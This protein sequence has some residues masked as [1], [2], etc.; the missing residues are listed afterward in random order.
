MRAN[1]LKQM[2]RRVLPTGLIR[3]LV[4]TSLKVRR[5]LIWPLTCPK[6][7][8]SSLRR[9][10]DQFQLFDYTEQVVRQ[11]NKFYATD[12]IAEGSRKQR[13]SLLILR[14]FNWLSPTYLWVLKK[15]D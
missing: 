6:L 2:L 7:N 5:F 4:D 10:V 13:L 9:L 11:P 15:H 14:L 3:K 1:R 12:M 8:V